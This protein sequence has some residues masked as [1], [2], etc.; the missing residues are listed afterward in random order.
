MNKALNKLTRSRMMAA[1]KNKNTLPELNIRKALFAKG[2]R[3][4]MHLKAFPGKPDLIFP[5]YKSVI[6]INGCFWHKHDC[7][8]SKIPE[9]NKEFWTH[10]LNE[11][12]QRDRKNIK[13]IQQM[14]WRVK[15][16]WLCALKNKKAFADEEDLQEVVNWIKN[17]HN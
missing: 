9:T 6:F 2:L 11:N 1:V 17:Y 8:L 14:G 5:K 16:I 13:E 3:Y 7:H 15:T 12:K 10:K 4:R